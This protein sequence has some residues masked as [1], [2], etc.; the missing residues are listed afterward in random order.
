MSDKEQRTGEMEIVNFSS[1]SDN[2]LSSSETNVYDEDELAKPPP[3]VARSNFLEG[4]EDNEVEPGLVSEA[5]GMEPFNLKE[6]RDDGFF[7]KE[8]YYIQVKETL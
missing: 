7:D 4:V 3:P 1:D 6:E 8:G 5:M 2:S